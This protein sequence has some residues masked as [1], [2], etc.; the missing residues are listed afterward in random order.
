MHPF[1]L[2]FSLETDADFNI[3]TEPCSQPLPWGTQSPARLACFLTR[4]YPPRSSASAQQ[5]SNTY[6]LLCYLLVFH[7]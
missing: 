5:T 2:S 4:I 7:P 1:D 3:L 6:L